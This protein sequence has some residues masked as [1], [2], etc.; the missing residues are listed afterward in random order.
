MARAE[1]TSPDSLVEAGAIAYVLSTP[2][3]APPVDHARLVE[4]QRHLEPGLRLQ[5][6]APVRRQAPALHHTARAHP[7]ACLRFA[8]CAA[9]R[10]HPQA[11]PRRVVG[12]R[13]ATAEWRACERD[14]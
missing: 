12:G 13:V 10:L 1:S 3:R 11:P 6:G 14:V 4:P 5:F 8:A 7:F 9:P 2:P